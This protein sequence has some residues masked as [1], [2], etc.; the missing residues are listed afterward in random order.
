MTYNSAVLIKSGDLFNITE[1]Y[2]VTTEASRSVPY[3]MKIIKNILHTQD[4]LL[5]TLKQIH[6]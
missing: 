4:V 2:I 5:I 1:G 6:S 3:Q